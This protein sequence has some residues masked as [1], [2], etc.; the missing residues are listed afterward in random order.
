MQVGGLQ[1]VRG[2]GVTGQQRGDVAVLHE[3]GEGAAGVAV[4]GEG[5]AEH[6]DDPAVLAVVAEHVV[7][8]V[9]VAAE[10]GLAAAPLAEGEDVPAL[11][12]GVKAVGPH[13]DALAAVLAPADDHR[14]P[15][16][17]AARLAHV[18]AVALQ[19]R[20]AVHA[21]LL[22][23]HPAP[24]HAEI[25]R[26]NAHRVV[27]FRRDAVLGRA[28]KAGVRRPVEPQGR[29]VRRGIG[30]KLQSHFHILPLR[31]AI[32]R[33]SF[34]SPVLSITHTPPPRHPLPRAKKR[35][36]ADPPLFCLS[37]GN[38]ARAAPL[39]WRPPRAGARKG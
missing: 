5:R 29:K 2:Q 38:I 22:G 30:R 37:P 3:L 31:R 27:V 4:K 8:L 32:A 28:R 35:G 12:A 34:F 23:E 7:E 15:G 39:P 36:G 6:P 13:E 33:Q 19:H 10:G 9:V 18:D 16:A 24:A 14:V 20:D 1:V 25:L 11:P 21:R 17:Q 26:E